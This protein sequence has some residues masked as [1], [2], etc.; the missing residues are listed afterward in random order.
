MN[1]S[2]TSATMTTTATPARSSID[3]LLWGM[4]IVAPLA[5][6]LL[7]PMRPYPGAAVLK[8]TMCVLLAVLAAR[9]GLRLF[10]I[11]LLLSAAGDAFLGIDG[12]RYFIPGLVS[13]LL[14]HVLYT[15]L[16]ARGTPV[17]RVPIRG[18]RIVAACVIPLFAIWFS[19]TLWPK[20]G[21]LAVPVVL[22]TAV[23][24]AMAMTSL[25]MAVV[26]I[27]LGA[28]FF[29]TS[30]SLLS[31]EKFIGAPAWVGPVVWAT[32]A[33]AQLLITYGVLQPSH[34]RDVGAPPTGSAS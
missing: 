6:L 22:Y 20:L 12:A 28:L 16:F 10:T 9:Q 32:Y 7:L 13:F 2:A 19:V 17:Q 33:I 30:D 11:A 26:T 31:L 14:T 15:V 25:R 18:W 21:A 1:P 24:V 5:Y 27:P 4:A 3:K 34:N 8:T 23:I 29:M